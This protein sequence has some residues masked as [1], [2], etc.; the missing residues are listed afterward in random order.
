[1]KVLLVDDSVFVR[2]SLKK[3][4]D[5]SGYSFTYE[6]ASTG[7]EAVRVYKQSSPDLVIMD[8]EMPEMNGITAIEKIMEIDSNAKIIMCSSDGY[9]ERVIQAAKAGAAY[10]IAKPYEPQNI[11][12]HVKKVLNL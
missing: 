4:L 6:E 8:N 2:T 11:I 12:D 1:M 3:L 7:K 5:D 10:F 9:R